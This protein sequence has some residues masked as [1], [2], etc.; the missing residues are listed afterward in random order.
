MV[1]IIGGG[2]VGAAATAAVEQTNF[3]MLTLQCQIMVLVMQ[4]LQL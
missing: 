4:Q 2:G 1:Q 3:G